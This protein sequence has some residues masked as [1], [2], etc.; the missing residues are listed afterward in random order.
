[1]SF[2]IP[3]FYVRHNHGHHNIIVRESNENCIPLG[4]G[5]ITIFVVTFPGKFLNQV[6]VEL[7]MWLI[8]SKLTHTV[9]IDLHLENIF[10][11]NPELTRHLGMT[12]KSQ[13]CCRLNL[14]KINCTVMYKKIALRLSKHLCPCLCG[15][16][17]KKYV[18]LYF[19]HNV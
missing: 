2:F 16:L 11:I 10:Q 6:S 1:M 14:R 7:Q 18:R 9:N 15:G 17:V 8:G 4:S 13:P 12:P 3:E 19:V 5:D